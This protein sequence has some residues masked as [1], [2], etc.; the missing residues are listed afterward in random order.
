MKHVV[1]YSGGICSWATACRVAERHGTDDLTLLF[2]D[3]KM[4]D[5]DL[6]RFLRESAVQVGGE[7]VEIA[8]GRTPWEVFKDVRFLGNSRADPCSR[9]LKRDLA[10]KW[11]EDNCDPE[12]TTLY[13]G[14]DWSEFHRLKP[15]VR[16]WEPWVIEAPMTEPPYR[17]RLGMA[18]DLRAAGL[19]PPRLYELGFPHNNCGGYCIKAGHAQFKMLLE[20]LP[21]RYRWHEEQE[22][23]LRQHLGKPVA[24]MRDRRGGTS[25]PLTMREFRE[26]IEAGGQCDLFDWGGCGCFSDV[27]EVDEA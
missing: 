20:T 23:A 22:E 11:V 18:D 24:I 8:D 15:V 13:I 25:T 4:E 14:I 17:T 12:D 19:K 6:Y 26:R 7:L 21:D 27:G 16:N 10:K 3:T 1:M 9:I 5:E 2:T